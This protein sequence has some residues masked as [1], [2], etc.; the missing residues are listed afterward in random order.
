[1]SLDYI[2]AVLKALG[3][4]N[5]MLSYIRALYSSPTAR[6]HVNGHLSNAFHLHNGTRQGCPLSPLLFILTLEPLLNRI[7]SNPDIRGITVAK[8]IYKLAA[9]ADDLLLFLSEPHISI[10]NLLKD[11]L[12]DHFQTFSNLKINYSKSNALNVTLS[13]DTVSQCQNNFPFTWAKDLITY[14]GIKIPKTLSNLFQIHFVQALKETREE[15][16]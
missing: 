11:L 7:R 10:P 6:V 16:K 13:S 2:D 4:P 1:M 5:L 3:L 12:K 8:Q 15:L 9:F 14:L